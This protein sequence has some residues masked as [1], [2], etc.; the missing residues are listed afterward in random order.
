MSVYISVM[1]GAK[2]A[3]MVFILIGSMRQKWGWLHFSPTTYWRHFRTFTMKM[4]RACP[5]TSRSW[6]GQNMPTWCSFSSAQWDKSE[7]GFT[8]LLL[9][10][11]AILG[12]LQWK[13]PEHV[14][15]HLCHGRGKIC[16]HGVHFN[17]LNETKVRMASLFSYH[18][19]A[20]F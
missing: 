8:F 13:W 4:T 1:G 11:G 16:Q 6:V 12:L 9:H 18:I 3:N 20:P 15:L 7:D 14:R 5:F 19:L 17:Q 2:Y 10:T